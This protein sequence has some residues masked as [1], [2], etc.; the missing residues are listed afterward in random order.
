MSALLPAPAATTREHEGGSDGICDHLPEDGVDGLADR[1]DAGHRDH[2]DQRGEK[3][4]FE[5]VLALV[6]DGDA[7]DALAHG[8]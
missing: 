4:V 6:I 7:S 5:Q 3:S 2:R 8:S 1:R